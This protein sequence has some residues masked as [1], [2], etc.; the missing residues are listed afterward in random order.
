MERINQGFKDMLGKTA[1]LARIGRHSGAEEMTIEGYRQIMIMQ[2]KGQR[3]KY[4][5]HATTIWLASE[6]SKPGSN[7]NL[8]PFGWV[9]LEVVE[10]DFTWPVQQC[11]TVRKAGD[12]LK[13][14]AEDEVDEAKEMADDTPNVIK[15]F[16]SFHS[17]PS[18]DNF[19]DF[20]KSI[21][22]DDLSDL[23]K[24][25]FKGMESAINIG[26]VSRLENLEVEPEIL[27]A[28]ASKVSEII[29]PT[30][31]W[32]DDKKAT[33]RRLKEMAGG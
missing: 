31:K 10:N 19:I 24:I 5:D 13:N 29:E 25:S 15:L 28:I 33:Y 22:K 11:K 12:G 16:N 17:A 30:K 2:G 3:P 27:K 26:V 18:P 4:L 7:K 6:T 20:I 9:V 14:G 1:F 23:N 8:T 32:S 21:T